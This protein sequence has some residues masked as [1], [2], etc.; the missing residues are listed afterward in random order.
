MKKKFPTRLRPA[1]ITATVR[2]RMLPL[3][4]PLVV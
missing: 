1:M 2:A 4:S 3:N